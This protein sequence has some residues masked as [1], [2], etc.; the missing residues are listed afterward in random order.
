MKSPDA[1]SQEP[2]DDLDFAILE[3]IREL[4]M[5]ADPMPADLPE[6]VTF[7]LEMRRLE[8][9]VARIVGADEPRLAAVRGEEHSRT[10][11]FDSDSL[12]VM[13]RIDQ[14][15]DGTVRIDGWLAPPQR[16]EIELQTAAD[17]QRVDSDELGRFA[18]T[19]VSHGTARLVVTAP[20]ERQG[21]PGR[22]VV[23]PQLILLGTSPNGMPS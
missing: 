19:R 21:G 22:P 6:R 13:I 10:V 1:A 2:M 18:F 5:Q 12:T 17:P 7:A 23:T 4:F 16:R 15:K 14:N 11:T 9:E 20:G 3:G 8:A